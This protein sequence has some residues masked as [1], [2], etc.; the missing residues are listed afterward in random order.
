MAF[1]K[2]TF[3]QRVLSAWSLVLQPPA[4][5]YLSLLFLA[6]RTKLLVGVNWVSAVLTLKVWDPKRQQERKCY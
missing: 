2:H 4:R 6:F 5:S 1:G 3:V